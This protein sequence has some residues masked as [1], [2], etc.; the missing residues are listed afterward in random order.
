MHY[1]IIFS[2]ILIIGVSINFLIELFPIKYKDDY[3]EDKNN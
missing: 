1:L 3:N 2:L